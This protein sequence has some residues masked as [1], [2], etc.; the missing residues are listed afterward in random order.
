AN[1]E[2]I[3]YEKAGENTGDEFNRKVRMNRM[4]LSHIVPTLEI[5]NFF[6]VKWFTYF[7]VGHRTSRYLLW[8][9]HLILVVTNFYLSFSSTTYA[10][11]L[12]FH[13]LILL[14]AIFQHVIKTKNTLLNLIYYYCITVLAQ[15]V[16]I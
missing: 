16:G 8:L 9:V 15:Y 12:F 5:L 11:I 4:L 3:A 2:A 7:Y 13:I 6:K 10:Y 14:S 1:H